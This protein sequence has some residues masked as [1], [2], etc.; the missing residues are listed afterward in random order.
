MM[1]SW[2]HSSEPNSWDPWNHFGPLCSF[3]PWK[4]PIFLSSFLMLLLWAGITTSIA[5]VWLVGKQLL[6]CL[7]L[8]VPQDSHLPLGI[9]DFHIPYVVKMLPCCISAC[10]VIFT[11]YILYCYYV[12]DSLWDTFAHLGST[13]R[14]VR[15]GELLPLRCPDPVLGLL[16]SESLCCPVGCPFLAIGRISWCQAFHLSVGGTSNAGAWSSVIVSPPVP[17]DRLSSAAWGTHGAAHLRG[18]SSWCCQG[19]SVFPPGLW[20]WHINYRPHSFFYS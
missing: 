8:E 18:P 4:S 13:V 14:C 17:H 19:C 16:W 6:A 20:L 2:D 1:I 9:G 10:A 5:I 12:L 15:C 3:S 11:S 7:E